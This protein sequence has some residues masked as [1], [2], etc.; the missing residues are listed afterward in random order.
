MVVSAKAK[1]AATDWLLPEEVAARSESYVVPAAPAVANRKAFPGTPAPAPSQPLL[2]GINLSPNPSQPTT[3]QFQTEISTTV[4]IGGQMFVVSSGGGDTLQVTNAT[5]PTNLPPQADKVVRVDLKGYNSQ[6]VASYGN[7]LAVALSPSDYTTNGGKGLVRFYRVGTDGT[8]AFLQDVQVGYLPDSIA[9]NDQGTK[10]VIANEGEPISGYA[11]DRSKDPAG[12]IG[13]IDIQG[14]VNPRFSYTDL[15]FDTVT[16][17]D[18]FRI[19][20]PKDTTQ[21]TDIEPEYVSI[22]G[23]VAYVTLQ[24]NNGVAKVNLATN[25]IEKIFALGTVASSRSWGRTSKACACRTA[26]PPTG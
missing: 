1:S 11:T 16:L 2:G 10:L 6:S 13:I 17:P 8:L 14:R 3:E 26:L 23:N 18:G 21:A 25:S 7:L 20:G 12:S 4:S 22:L 5:D 24:E 9:F 19:S 15:R